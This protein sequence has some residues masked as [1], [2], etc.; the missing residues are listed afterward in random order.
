MN[1]TRTGMGWGPR[2]MI[3]LVLI[4][5]RRRRRDMGPRATIIRGAFSRRG[6]GAAAAGHAH[7]ETG[8]HEPAVR[9]AACSPSARRKRRTRRSRA[10]KTA[11]QRSRMPPHGRTDRQ[12]APMRS[13]LLSQR[14]ARSIAEWRLAISRTFSSTASARSI[15]RRSR[16]IITASRQPV[17]L[18]DLISEY[19]ALGPELRRGGPQDSWWTDFRA[20]SASWSKSIAPRGRRSIRKRATNGARRSWS[21][22]DV[23]QA[24][25]ETMRLPGA[26]RAGAWIGKARRYI[27]AHRALDEIESAA[28]MP[29]PPRR[30]DREGLA[31]DS[32]D[33][34]LLPCTARVQLRRLS[35]CKQAEVRGKWRIHDV[36]W[37]KASD[38]R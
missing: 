21:A 32:R 16:P 11:S 19:D 35:F 31:S 7:S 33:A 18:D 10:W 34:N 26:A 24:L 2:M 1:G 5:A 36:T 25:A 20:S 17:R 15:R 9:A 3:A 23:D 8:G 6:S 13:S 4:I 28:L 14:G 38:W 27:A 30:T 29:G 22:G 37:E 12:D